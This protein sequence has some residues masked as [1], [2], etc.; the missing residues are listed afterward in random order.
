MIQSVSQVLL[1]GLQ[2]KLHQMVHRR[3]DDKNGYIRRSIRA[4]YDGAD[5]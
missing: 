3:F 1:G 5:V 2:T 4:S